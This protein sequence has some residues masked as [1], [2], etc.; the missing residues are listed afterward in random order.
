MNQSPYT[1]A[2][3]SLSV[4]PGAPP[5]KRPTAEEI[6]SFPNEAQKLITWNWNI[7][8]KELQTHMFNLDWL[9]GRHVLIAGGTGNG[10]GCAL[11]TAIIGTH[12]AASITVVARDLSKSL[13]FETGKELQT[14]AQ[15]KECAL[16]FC[17]RG[18]ATNGPAFDAIVHALNSVNAKEVVYFNTVAA[19]VSGLTPNLP[20]VYVKDVN[21]EHG[22]FQ[23]ELQPLSSKEIE[24]TEH[25]MGHLAVEFPKALSE[26]GIHPTLSVFSDWRGSLDTASRN[27]NSN[28]YGRQGA[29]STSLFLPKDVIHQTVAKA[30]G[31]ETRMI[32]IYLPA[33]K[34]RALPLIPGGLFMA[35]MY[36]SIMKTHGESPKSIPALALEMLDTV[37]NTFESGPAFNPFPRLDGYEAKYDEWFYEVAP[38]LNT[39]ES[40]PFYYK[41]WV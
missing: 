27:P 33:M 9:N 7:Q 19:A 36:E 15:S 25:V 24:M 5:L 32:D 28:L 6:A 40:S 14:F 35:N 22:L 2:D 8:S 1:K 39:D 30:Y 10:I 37:G 31:T 34:T 11:A 21:A 18:V 17:P 20:P 12:K 3:P 26:A 38:R 13:N 29:Y 23:W 4:I 41:R 16:Q